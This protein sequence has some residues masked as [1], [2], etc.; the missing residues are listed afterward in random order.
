MGFSAELTKDYLTG[1]HLVRWSLNPAK[2][3]DGAQ[4]QDRPHARSSPITF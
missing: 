3:G 2:N 1:R 4:A